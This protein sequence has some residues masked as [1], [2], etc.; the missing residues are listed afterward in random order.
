MRIAY[1]LLLSFFALHGAPAFAEV[2]TDDRL[3]LSTALR[4]DVIDG[5]TGQF[6]QHLRL[7][8]TGAYNRQIIPEIGLD[9][10][11]VS[12]VSVGVGARYGF[13]TVEENETTRAFRMH[14]DLGLDS[15]EL[16]P[17]ELG[18][19]LRYQSESSVVTEEPKNRIRN[20]L[21]LK[22]STGTML[23]PGA[24][25]EH[26]M[27]PQGEADQKAQ[28]QRFGGDLSLK[29]NK[30]HRLRLKYFQDTEIDGDGDKVRVTAMAYRYSL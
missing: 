5:L 22:V 27:D 17:L 29:L 28:K 8:I 4:G 25:Y 12:L 13:E 7:P 20:R 3:W 15:P 23:R 2:T 14:G 10:T 11:P 6:T 9:Y 24:F 19:R 1:G 16:G 30:R 26:F 21:S 18:Y